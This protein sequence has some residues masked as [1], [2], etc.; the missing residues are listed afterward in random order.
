M[1]HA[2]IGA[3]DE[4]QWLCVCSGQCDASPCIRHHGFIRQL[5]ALDSHAALLL[6]LMAVLHRL[7]AYFIGL[8]ATLRLVALRIRCSV[9][10]L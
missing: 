7:L 8:A 1:Q 3:H 6:C 2:T 9:L 10:A 5:I 4:Y